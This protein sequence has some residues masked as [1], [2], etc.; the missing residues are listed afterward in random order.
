MSDF[1]LPPRRTK[2]HSK[3]RPGQQPPQQQQQQA[4]SRRHTGPPA[5]PASRSDLSKARTAAP[6]RSPRARLPPPAGGG[7]Y[8]A[9]PSSDDH[10]PP[11][12]PPPT[13]TARTRRGGGT[14]MPVRFTLS[15]IRVDD[16]RPVEAY[17]GQNDPYVVLRIGRKITARTSVKDEAGAAADWGAETLSATATQGPLRAGQVVLDVLDDNGS[18]AKPTRIGGARM[19]ES[20]LASLLEG[21]SDVHFSVLLSSEG[22][23]AGQLTAVASLEALAPSD[24][25]F[26]AWLQASPL[27]I[28]LSPL[29]TPI[30]FL[31]Q[32]V[33]I[34]GKLS[35][36]VSLPSWT[37]PA[38]RRL[39][40][41]H[42]RRPTLTPPSSTGRAALRPRP[43]PRHGGHV[44]QPRHGRVLDPLPHAP[45]Y[46]VHFQPPGQ[47]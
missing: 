41:R 15:S 28:P 26:S 29:L 27:Q 40:R 46:A 9:V 2:S 30:F 37:P 32:V 42:R 22:V 31:I 4:P 33:T 45:P 47:P 23:A 34:L 12:P 35:A 20:T 10:P 21:S 7:R 24:V 17:G 44:R 39:C 6:P 19:G 14:H 18:L 43:A 8:A 25:S 5:A 36:V 13:N 16:L 1:S 38:V 11:R 3:S